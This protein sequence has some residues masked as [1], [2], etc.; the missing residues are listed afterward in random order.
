MKKINW[1]DSL[2]ESLSFPTLIIA[3][4]LIV[5][6]ANKKFLDQYGYREDEL[7]G[8]T[9]NQILCKSAGP[10]PEPSC[11]I[12]RVLNEGKG[13]SEIAKITGSDGQGMLTHNR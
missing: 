12:S 1:H 4:D 13:A 6:M 10:C 8:K 5:V 2:F 11:P 7:I 9:C 3:A